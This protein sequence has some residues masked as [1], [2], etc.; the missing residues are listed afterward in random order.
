MLFKTMKI[1]NHK[2]FIKYWNILCYNSSSS[3]AY[4][5]NKYCYKQ[6]LVINDPFNSDAWRKVE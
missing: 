4:M 5:I 2:K 1:E 3:N 6:N